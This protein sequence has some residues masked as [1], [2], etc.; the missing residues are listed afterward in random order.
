VLGHTALAD[1]Q[2]VNF[3][4]K[5]I[6]V[7]RV[8]YRG[9]TPKERADRVITQFTEALSNPEH[10]SSEIKTRKLKDGSY[11]VFIRKIT[12]LTVTAEDAKAAMST[13]AKLASAWQK[14]LAWAFDE[15]KPI[16]DIPKNK[17]RT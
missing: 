15:S 14:N 17:S 2:P 11:E 7:F 6:G 5:L 12:F 3:A 16:K 4:G 10:K 1:Y 8:S 13:P 9:I